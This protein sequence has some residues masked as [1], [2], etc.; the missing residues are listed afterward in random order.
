MATM[1]DGQAGGLG[2]RP[3]ALWSWLRGWSLWSDRPGWG[4]AVSALLV[5]LGLFA[6][7]YLSYGSLPPLLPLHYNAAGEVDLIG[8]PVELFKL[9]AIGGVVFLADLLLAAGLHRSERFAALLLLGGCVFVE[10]LL[11]AATFNVV[12]LA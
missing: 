5:N 6:Y 4:L 3:A 1:G 8:G 11:F 9:P 12:R 2:S 7:V 10:V